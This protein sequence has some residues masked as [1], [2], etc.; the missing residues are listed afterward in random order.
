MEK[1]ARWERNFEALKLYIDSN[2]HAKV[3]SAYMTQLS[4]GNRTGLGTW[5]AYMR[6]KYRD[7][8]L[9]EEKIVAFEQLIGWV[10]N[11]GRPGPTGNPKRDQEILKARSAGAHL[12]EIADAYDLSRQRV[13][14]IVG[15]AKVFNV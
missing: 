7:G 15:R 14:Q 10:W 2:G 5:V 8:T 13:H 12:Q 1:N 4:D 11:P 9:D 3:P 6:K